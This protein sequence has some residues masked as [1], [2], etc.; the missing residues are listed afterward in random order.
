[1]SDDLRTITAGWDPVPG[2]VAARW[3]TGEDG[4]RFVQLRLD[5][6][7]FQMEV[8]GRPDGHRP[9]GYDSLLDY[10]LRLERTSTEAKRPKL[11]WA[12]CT[13]LQQ[14]A[15]QYYHRYLAF[16]A[17]D[18]HEGV[19]R[20]TEH[21]LALIQLVRRRAAEDHLAWQFVQFYPYVRMMNAQAH[22]QLGLAAHH[23]DEAARH[24]DTAIE[25]IRAFAQEHGI[26]RAGAELGELQ[27]L[28][29]LRGRIRTSRRRDPQERMRQELQ[30]AIETEDFER[31]AVLREQLKHPQ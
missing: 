22:A 30:R 23:P 14:E 27:A 10:Q 21:N 4:H 5:L 9:H 18:H 31:A 3:A 7:V 17:L 8:E 20:D 13:E 28:T 15:V 29:E 25:E 6:G 12:A 26:E 1:M 2:G 11:D 19:I 16:S 24:V